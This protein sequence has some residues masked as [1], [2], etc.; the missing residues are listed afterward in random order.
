[1]C[2]CALFQRKRWIDDKTIRVEWYWMHSVQKIL[3]NSL[4][5]VR[6]IIV[7]AFFISISL[8]GMF[9]FSSL[10]RDQAHSIT[11]PELLFVR[12]AHVFKS[13]FKS[14]HSIRK[15]IFYH[16][17]FIFINQEIQLHSCS[18]NNHKV[19]KIPRIWI[20][21]RHCLHFC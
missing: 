10:L 16:G 3:F 21:F 14:I 8:L 12:T 15:S 9:C 1:M 17:S 19:H 5:S 2:V 7:Q 6:V 13:F 20:I 18:V 11:G 4:S